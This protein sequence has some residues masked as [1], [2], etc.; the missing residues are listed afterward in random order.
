MNMDE[1]TLGMQ[2]KIGEELENYLKQ[3]TDEKYVHIGSIPNTAGIYEIRISKYG[4]KD[5]LERVATINIKLTDNEATLQLNDLNGKGI[6]QN[7]GAPKTFKPV[8]LQGDESP[9]FKQ[10]KETALEIV[11]QIQIQPKLG[12]ELKELIE[13]VAKPKKY[14]VNAAKNRLGE[15]E[16]K[17]TKEVMDEVDDVI[18]VVT[19]STFHNEATAYFSGVGKTDRAYPILVKNLLGQTVETKNYEKFKEKLLKDIINN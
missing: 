14:E 5:R 7:I 12:D 8:T 4:F 11:N 1:Q 15:Y 9:E 6:I 3:A 2:I 16:I 10:L 13:E 17:V 19:I 18:V